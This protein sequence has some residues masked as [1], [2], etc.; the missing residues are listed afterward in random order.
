MEVTFWSDMYG[1][2]PNPDGSYGIEIL[3]S[4]ENGLD[5]EEWK[6]N[7]TTWKPDVVIPPFDIMNPGWTSRAAERAHAI[8][9]NYTVGVVVPGVTGTSRMDFFM[10]AQEN[11]YGPIVFVPA[12]HISRERQLMELTV[13][14]LIRSTT[15]IHFADGGD[16]MFDTT[17]FPGIYTESDIFFKEE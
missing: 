13:S 8:I 14:N 5:I 12:R 10:W 3:V 9:P 2:C 6:A 11:D 17:A 16:P 4:D 1:V 7:V 15:W